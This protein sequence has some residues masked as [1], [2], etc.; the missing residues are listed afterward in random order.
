M[1]VSEYG[2]INYMLKDLVYS[3]TT[4]QEYTGGG[5]QQETS[6]GLLIPKK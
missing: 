2:S 3:I 6:D 5:I 1:V 4:S